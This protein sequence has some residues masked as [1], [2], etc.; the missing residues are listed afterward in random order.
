MTEAVPEV[1]R[2]RRP[3]PRAASSPGKTSTTAGRA[4]PRSTPTSGDGPARAGDEDAAAAVDGEGEAEEV[5]RRS[6]CVCGIIQAISTWTTAR[7]T[8]V[9]SSGRRRPSG[10][11]QSAH[12]ASSIGR[13]QSSRTTRNDA[14][15][16]RDGDAVDDRPGR[17]RRRRR[18][19]RRAD[20]RRGPGRPVRP[21]GPG[22]RRELAQRRAR[23]QVADP[24]SVRRQ[25]AS[26]ATAG[27]AARRPG[28]AP[29]RGGGT[30]QRSRLLIGSG[31]P[32][33]EPQ[34]RDPP[35]A[36]DLRVP[37]GDDRSDRRSAVPAGGEAADEVA[38]AAGRPQPGAVRRAA[39][40]AGPGPAARR[41]RPGRPRCR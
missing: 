9:S 3:G 25:P 27:R 10:S 1:D 26:P 39:R 23:G 38:Q 21:A 40:R 16:V 41:R 8:K 17:A 33:P 12:I 30:D 14:G 32:R 34:F 11:R 36:G 35:R 6:P 15:Q 22:P 31:R 13:S 37:L 20:P 18:P 4:R 28:A 7:T 29:R 5:V 19:S 24:A 2:D